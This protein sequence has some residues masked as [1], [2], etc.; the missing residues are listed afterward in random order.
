MKLYMEV[1]LLVGIEISERLLQVFREIVQVGV[2]IADEH[3][4][5]IFHELGKL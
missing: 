5:D 3:H 4:I 2:D 1:N